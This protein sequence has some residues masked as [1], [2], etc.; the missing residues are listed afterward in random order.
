MSSFNNPE[1]AGAAVTQYAPAIYSSGNVISGSAATQRLAGVHQN[2]IS[3]ADFAA[4]LVA[5][6][7]ANGQ[8]I[9]CLVDG[10]G[11]AVVA[12]DL[13]MIG[14]GKLVKYVETAGNIAVAVACEPIAADGVIR[15]TTTPGIPAEP[16]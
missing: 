8:G 15:I 5:T 6:S 9:K 14:T 7:V 13:L 10:S 2:T 11:T 1:T 16:A 4:G 12:G 3:A